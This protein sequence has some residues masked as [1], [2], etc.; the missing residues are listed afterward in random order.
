VPRILAA[1]LATVLVASLTACASVDDALGNAAD[2]GAAAAGSAA[3]AA[4]LHTDGRALTPL[5]DTVLADA[6]GELTDASRTVLELTPDDPDDETARDAVERALRDGIDAVTG[7]RAALARGDDL[8][9]WVDR[10]EATRDAL[11][12]AA[13]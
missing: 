7:A 11:A 4:G 9:P 2:A 13:P 8:G 5:T 3:I 6:V 1:L 10:L 12:K